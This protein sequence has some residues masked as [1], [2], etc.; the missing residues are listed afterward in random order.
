MFVK[1][2]NLSDFEGSIILIPVNSMPTL[3]QS[4]L[5]ISSFPNRITDTIFFFVKTSAAIKTLSSCDSGK[6]IVF[7]RSL[8]FDFIFYNNF[9]PIDTPNFLRFKD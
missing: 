6:T 8:A 7:L 5:I 9:N 1:S 2:L 3:L 4:F